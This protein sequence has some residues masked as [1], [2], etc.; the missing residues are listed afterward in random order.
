MR[1]IVTVVDGRI[2][3]FVRHGMLRVAAVKFDGSVPC[4]IFTQG[5]SGDVDVVSSPVRELSARVLVPPAEFIVTSSLNVIDLGCRPQPEIPIQ[6][7]G[8]IHFGKGAAG[9]AAINS[10]RHLL[11]VAQQSLLHHVD[12]AQKPA[13]VAPLLSPDEEDLVGVLLA[14]VSDQLVLLQRQRERLLHEDVFACLQRFDG[15]FHVPVVR[16]HDAHDVDVVPIEHSSVVAIRI[17][18]SLAN[19]LVVLSS[20]GMPGVNIADRDNIPEVC[21]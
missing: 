21:M 17:G 16:C 7:G 18:F 12:G 6:F 19:S 5:P 15:D 4:F 13:T 14:R 9:R 8:R 3:V 1:C 11:N 2:P 10:H 20:L